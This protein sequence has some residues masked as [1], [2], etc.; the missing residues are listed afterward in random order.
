MYIPN[1]WKKN[2]VF[3]YDSQVNEYTASGDTIHMEFGYY[4]NPLSNGDWHKIGN[5]Y[6]KIITPNHDNKLTGAY[7]PR[8]LKINGRYCSFNIYGNNLT[9]QTHNETLNAI[10]TVKFNNRYDLSLSR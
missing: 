7:I 10:S 3:G 6:A 9:E 8:I 2:L 4:T 5:N 1:S